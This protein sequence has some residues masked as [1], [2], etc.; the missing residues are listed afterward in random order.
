MPVGSTCWSTGP[1]QASVWGGDDRYKGVLPDLMFPVD[2][3]WLL[4]TLWDDD[5]TCIGGSKELVGAI[6][7]HAELCHRARE[8]DPSVTDATPP[9]HSAI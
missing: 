3:S 9:G 8:V 1:E 2:R 5:W 7:A 4:S 6:L